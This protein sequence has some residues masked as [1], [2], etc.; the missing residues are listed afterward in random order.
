MEMEVIRAENTGV[1]LYIIKA[2][3]F[4]IQYKLYVNEFMDL[5]KIHIFVFRK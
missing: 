1:K 4:H 2:E 5:L 3:Y